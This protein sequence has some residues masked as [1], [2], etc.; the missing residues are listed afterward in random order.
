VAD[1]RSVQPAVPVGASL[2]FSLALTAG[3]AMF[4]AVGAFTSQLARTRRRAAGIAGAVLGAAFLVRLVADSG[5]GLGWLRWASPIGWVEE[6]RPL[7]GSHL[8][9]LVPIVAF[10][11]VLSGLSVKLAGVRDL[12]AG[13]LAESDSSRPRTALLGSPARLAVRLARP[14]ALT[15]LA[16]IA[17]LAFVTGAVAKAA[18]GAVSGSPSIQQAIERLGGRRFGAEAYLAISLLTV[19]AVIAL[20]AAGQ[21]AS[22]REEEAAGRLDHLLVRPVGRFSW[23]GGRLAVGAVVLV[24]GGAVAGVGT[25]AGAASQHSGLGFGPLLEAGVNTVPPALFLLGF[26]TLIYGVAPRLVTVVTYGLVAWSFLVEFIGS[27]VKFSHWV[28]DTSLFFHL[29]PAPA[30][31]PNWASAA[32]LV[33]LGILGAALGG[34]ALRRRDLVGA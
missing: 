20:V 24:V 8:F 19:A 28:L 4:L 6:M 3:A 25:W 21:A 23:L 2:Y 9:A 5:S 10:V 30:A 31:S 22:S 27:V 15:W 11:V 1:G 33:A 14:V 16:A 17:V 13:A 29:A 7:T 32:A 34:A 18:A 26:G 12:G